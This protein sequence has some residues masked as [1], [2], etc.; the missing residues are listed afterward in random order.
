MVGYDDEDEWIFS[1]VVEQ[2]YCLDI[3]FSPETTEVFYSYL[4]TPYEQYVRQAPYE[5]F[6][7]GNDFDL[8]H[9]S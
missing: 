4:Y 3:N 9:S 2:G 7:G 6:G 5:F 8:S 1:I